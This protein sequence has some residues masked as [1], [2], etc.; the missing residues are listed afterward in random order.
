MI[1]GAR[2]FRVAS[3]TVM[4][5]DDKAPV[6]QYEGH[7]DNLQSPPVAILAFPV[8]L[9]SAL[10]SRGA[11][12]LK[13]IAPQLITLSVCLLLV[14]LI[15]LLSVF[16]GWFVWKNVVVGWETPVYLQYG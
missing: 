13:P 16:A 8:R 14:P 1:F 12:Y 7:D 11:G 3:H 4:S 5:T 6:R 9:S 15:V 10:V 2:G